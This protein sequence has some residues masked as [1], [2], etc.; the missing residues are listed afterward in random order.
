MHLAPPTTLADDASAAA[1][2]RSSTIS[3]RRG[4]SLVGMKMSAATRA[5]LLNMAAAANGDA[6]HA[7]AKRGDGDHGS[8]ASAAGGAGVSASRGS[9]KGPNPDG[10]QD[11]DANG[12]MEVPHDN[13]GK[14]FT[15][16]PHGIMDWI[17]QH[18]ARRT[19]SSKTWLNPGSAGAVRIARSGGTAGNIFDVCDPQNES[20]VYTGNVPFS[21]YTLDLQ[22][23]SVVPTHYALKHGYNAPNVRGRVSARVLWV[24]GLYL[25][26][27]LA[28][29]CRCV[30]P[31]SIVGASCDERS[32]R[33]RAYVAARGEGAGAELGGSGQA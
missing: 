21:Y 28:G 27:T 22:E 15:M 26:L 18:V 3:R 5:S 13:T 4:P 7:E 11:P 1:S 6:P 30:V 23:Y 32:P 19:F 8:V 31:A 16:G 14:A 33:G 17:G 10:G 25:K 24:C 20:S 12:G 29:V 9:I 2:R